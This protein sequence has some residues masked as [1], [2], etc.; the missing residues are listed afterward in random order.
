MP[1]KNPAFATFLKKH[2][3]SITK[4]RTAVFAA[5]E[6]S[7]P[8]SMHELLERLPKADR[9]SVYRVIGLFEK[10][11]I[12]K[13]IQIGWKYKLELSDEFSY[14]H[15]HISCTNC[16]II[17]PLREHA[18]VETVITALSREYGFTPS[19]HQLEIQ[20]LCSRCQT[21]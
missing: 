5:L 2:G 20:G 6:D 13:R 1:T 7:E 15:H 8:Q 19:D 17:V 14:H 11:G 4:V 16:G 12:V 21:K 3:H 10:L 18:T 9:A